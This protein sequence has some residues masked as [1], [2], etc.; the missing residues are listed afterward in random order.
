[1]A[2]F[3]KFKNIKFFACSRHEREY[4]YAFLLPKISRFLRFPTWKKKY[5]KNIRQ[6]IYIIYFKYIKNL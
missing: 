3:W 6:N 1:M 2:K 5:D 4:T